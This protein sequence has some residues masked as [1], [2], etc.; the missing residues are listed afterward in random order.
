MLV[1]GLF[2]LDC[3][4]F[5]AG[6]DKSSAVDRRSRQHQPLHP[7]GEGSSHLAF[8]AGP[9]G[10]RKEGGEGRS[11]RRSE[12][13]KERTR[14]NH[15]SCLLMSPGHTK[16]GAVHLRFSG[17]WTNKQTRSG[18]TRLEDCHAN[19]QFHKISQRGVTSLV[20]SPEKERK[21]CKNVEPA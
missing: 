7:A 2:A 14:E 12:R 3:V 11:E 15:T 16:G 1:R 18:Q 20:P 4:T 13:A 5:E 10:K 17:Q 19:E 8:I 21:E 9:H 6:K